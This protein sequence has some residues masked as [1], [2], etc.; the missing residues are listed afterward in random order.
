M[1]NDTA[2]HEDK[3]TKDNEPG[4]FF[5]AE[6]DLEKGAERVARVLLDAAEEVEKIEKDIE[7]HLKDKED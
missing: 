5:K 2:S 7:R 6:F 3:S 4:A 1:S